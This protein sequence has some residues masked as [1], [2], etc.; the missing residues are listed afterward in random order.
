MWPP[1]AGPFIDRPD[2]INEATDSEGIERS[3]DVGVVFDDI[4]AQERTVLR[5]RY[6]WFAIACTRT[7][8]SASPIWPHHP[9]ELIEA[10]TAGELAAR[11]DHRLRP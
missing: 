10:D 8:W 5:A 6:P 9:L 1:I 3:D 11:I 4:R 2:L 7:G